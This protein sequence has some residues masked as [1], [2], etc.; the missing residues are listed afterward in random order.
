MALTVEDG[1]GVAGADSYSSTDDFATW[2]AGVDAEAASAWADLSL[3]AQEALL[4]A[5]SAWLD[6]RYLWPG[7]P[8]STEQGL[9]LPRDGD[10][11]DAQGRVFA[12]PTVPPAALEALRRA[13]VAELVDGGVLL[14]VDA[15]GVES[16]RAEG[17][18]IRYGPGSAERSFVA[19]DRL[20][21]GLYRAIAGKGPR[22]LARA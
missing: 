19:I 6:S 17:H 15:S 21:A 20:L 22:R 18:W 3:D 7:A 5:A 1:T 4:R 12:S 16:E 9:G 14:S 13:L 10:L 2:V 11:V 8:V